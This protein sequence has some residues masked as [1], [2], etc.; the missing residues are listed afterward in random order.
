[1]I[2]QSALKMRLRIYLRRECY[3]WL[4]RRNHSNICFGWIL[5]YAV[6]DCV[7]FRDDE[8]CGTIRIPLSEIESCGA[9]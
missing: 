8:N 2:A 5:G 9:V 7:L 4:C 1:M 3:I 6:N